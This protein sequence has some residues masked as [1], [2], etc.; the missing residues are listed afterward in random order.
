MWEGSEAFI[1]ARQF[2]ELWGI[3]STVLVDERAV[4]PELLGIRGVPTNV[5]VDEDGTIREIGASTPSALEAAIAR[6]LGPRVG[7]DAAGD[8]PAWS[9]GL[10]AGHI[11]RELA[12]RVAQRTVGADGDMAPGAGAPLD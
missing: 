12:R 3:R 5:L 6:L 4:L 2:C 9:R 11:E 8:R 10:P 7:F 1:E